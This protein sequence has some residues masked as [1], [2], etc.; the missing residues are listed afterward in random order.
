MARVLLAA[1]EEPTSN[2]VIARLA[3]EGAGHIVQEVH[4]GMSVLAAVDA[5]R[6]DALVLDTALPELDGFQVLDRMRRH[7]TLRHMPVVMLSTIPRDVGGELARSM[8]ALRFLPKPFTAADL[9]EA[10]ETALE[11]RAAG[12]SQVA[13]PLQR[14]AARS[15]A[16]WRAR[17]AVP[18]SLGIIDLFPPARRRPPRRRA[19]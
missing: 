6:P 12:A 9:N 11:A 16:E 8:G 4:D 19:T 5:Q 14:S 1:E 18:E 10:V 17:P 2:R 3:L 7:H 13:A 15:A